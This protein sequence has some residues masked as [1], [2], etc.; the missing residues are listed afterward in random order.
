M[1]RLH[2]MDGVD[3]Q[4]KSLGSGFL[5]AEWRILEGTMGGNRKWENEQKN[6][7]TDCGRTNER[8][9]QQAYYI[10]NLQSV[11]IKKPA[12]LYLM[13]GVDSQR[14]HWGLIS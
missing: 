2:W 11:R 13:D 9:E 8:P 5:R 6:A 10:N 4:G 3:A 12:R 7:S 14:G 1:A